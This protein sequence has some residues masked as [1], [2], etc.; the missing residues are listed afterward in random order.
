MFS[1]FHR[2]S[3]APQDQALRAFVVADG[4]MARSSVGR[5]HQPS[6]AGESND[7]TLPGIIARLS[8]LETEDFSYDELLHDFAS[9]RRVGSVKEP[10][11]QHRIDPAEQTDDIVQVI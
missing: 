1:T 7:I 6:L 11:V 8:R 9:R 5:G 2:P 4:A 3:P 10:P